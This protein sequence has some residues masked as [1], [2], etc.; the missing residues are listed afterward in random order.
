[1]HMLIT[2]TKCSNTLSKMESHDF[3]WQVNEISLTVPWT[4]YYFLRAITLRQTINTFHTS[5]IT[6]LWYTSIEVFAWLHNHKPYQSSMTMTIGNNYHWFNTTIFTS[7]GSTASAGAEMSIRT[8]VHPSHSGTVSRWTKLVSWF[9]S[10][11]EKGN[12][13]VNFQHHK[14]LLVCYNS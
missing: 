13:W 9:F 4:C 12:A 1:M 6:P 7:M 2:G 10:H 3:F 11:S 8:S 5:L 14:S